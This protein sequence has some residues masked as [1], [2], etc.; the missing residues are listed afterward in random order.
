MGPGLRLFPV[1][2]SGRRCLGG[3]GARASPVSGRCQRKTMF[4]GRW[5]QGFA[6]FRSL[7]AE[8]DVMGEVGPGLCLFPV[9]VSGRRCLGGGG[10]RAS[11]VSGPCQRK[12]MFRG[13]WGQGFA[14]FRSL[15]AEDDV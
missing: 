3:G 2:V 8:D 11:P 5:G 9:A 1:A 10:A 15:S 6:C 13:R 7:S 12:T 4:R 14:C